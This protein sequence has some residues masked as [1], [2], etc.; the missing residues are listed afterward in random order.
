[1][2]EGMVGTRGLSSGMFDSRLVFLQPGLEKI[3]CIQQQM[4]FLVYS[5]V[6]LTCPSCV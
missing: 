4:L 2:Y 5:E 6:S 3:Y 1:M